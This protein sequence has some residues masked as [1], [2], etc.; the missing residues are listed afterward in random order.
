MSY[1]ENKPIS[2]VAKG[3]PGLAFLAYPEIVVKLPFAPVWAIMFF[4]MLIV[5][6][7]DSQVSHNF[8]LEQ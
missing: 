4:L 8:F 5:L 1:V 2:E 7:T 6:G 3:G